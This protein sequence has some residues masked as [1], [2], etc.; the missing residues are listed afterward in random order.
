MMTCWW[1]QYRG[2]DAQQAMYKIRTKAT[3][4]VCGAISRWRHGII[5]GIKIFCKY[6]GWKWSAMQCNRH[7]AF[8][9]SSCEDFREVC[10]ETLSGYFPGHAFLLYEHH[11][12][13]QADDLI[14]MSSSGVTDC[15][16]LQ[17]HHI[18]LISLWIWT[19]TTK[20]SS[21]AVSHLLKATTGTID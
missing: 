17:L 7:C 3:I 5:E 10:N 19:Q 6:M 13:Q 20:C 14:Q 8:E 16:R 1:Q 18:L 21:C 9:L 2:L 12:K 15:P 4:R 11:W